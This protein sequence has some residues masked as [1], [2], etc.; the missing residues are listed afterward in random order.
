MVAFFAS[1]RY[2][3][4][5]QL[6]GTWE[7]VATPKRTLDLYE[8]RTYSLR[9]SGKALGFLSDLVG[10]EKGEWKVEGDTLVLSYTSPGNEAVENTR[11]FRINEMS[12][13]E[14]VLSGDRWRRL[15]R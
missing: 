10:P 11:R 4:E 9:L 14:I 6:V 8:D 12:G 1:C 2:L 5:R 3:R 13:D 15:R 7:S